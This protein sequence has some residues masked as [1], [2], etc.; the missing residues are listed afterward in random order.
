MLRPQNTAGLIAIALHAKRF[1]C[2]ETDGVQL[3]STGVVGH[4]GVG[5]LH[6]D[7]REDKEASHETIRG[8]GSENAQ[9]TSPSGIRP[10]YG[11]GSEH[12]HVLAGTLPA[13]GEP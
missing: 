7:A 13:Q 10:E 5:R 4:R 9:R 2:G 8:H 11:F 3:E 6:R 1:M 12:F